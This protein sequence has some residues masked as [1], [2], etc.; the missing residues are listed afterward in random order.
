MVHRAGL[1][2]LGVLP[3]GMVWYTLG[4]GS[5]AFI[6]V[7]ILL[8]AWAMLLFSFTWLH[9]LV[10]LMVL[11][12]PV[13]VRVYPGDTGLSLSVP[14]EMLAGLVFLVLLFRAAGYR[15][16]DKRI[17]YHP[18]TILLGI[19]LAWM[20]ITTAT[21]TMP[22]VS[23]K[24]T[25][26]RML[27]VSVFYMVLAHWFA[28]PRNMHR[29][30]WLYAGS[31]VMVALFTLYQHAPLGFTPQEAFEVTRPLFADHTIYGAALA[32]LMPYGIIALY[33]SKRLELQRWFPWLAISVFAFLT[34]ALFFSYSRAAWIS[35]I[36]TAIVAV[37]MWLRIGF[38]W[39]SALVV[40]VAAIGFWQS[41]YLINRFT[42][43]VV[44][45]S[46]S[47]QEQLLSVT[48]IHTDASNVER[49]NRWKCAIRM[50]ED[51]PHTGFGPGTYQFEYGPYQMRH[52]MTYLSTY[53]GIF[54]NAHSEYL[55]AL[56]E[57]GWPGMLFLLAWV[58]YTIWLGF[59]LVYHGHDP[60][61]RLMAAAA[62]LGL[63]SFFIHGWVNAFLDQDKIALPVFGLMAMLVALDVKERN[64]SKS[65]G[66][67]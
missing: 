50:W 61:T 26:A 25:G 65:A 22:L 67:R 49:I 39:Q 47:Y 24:R 46:G 32:I 28:E 19:E 17:L 60:P 35:V 40:L 52:E 51:R 8:T 21:G 38:W 42:T 30:W 62:L 18:I 27:Y 12:V 54:G 37:C 3:A 44:S 64:S 34:M 33:F 48:N 14:S 23:L 2:L 57:S 56:S 10:M 11:S 58:V 45:Q 66:V 4:Y 1:L 15:S 29:F 5:E 59:R 36:I 13:S 53:H 6:A 43:R 63:L 41:D 55:G 31:M 7:G 9:A 16:I 20:A